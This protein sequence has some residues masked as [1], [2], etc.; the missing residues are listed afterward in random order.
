V[1]CFFNFE[2]P[3]CV[4]DF[5]S[6]L[7]RFGVVAIAVRPQLL[8]PAVPFSNLGFQIFNFVLLVLS[9]LRQSTD[10]GLDLRL[11]LPFIDHLAVF[12]LVRE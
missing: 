5:I 10:L 4:V 3:F 6:E 2:I 11:L 9:R 12:F 8:D 7:R 1:L